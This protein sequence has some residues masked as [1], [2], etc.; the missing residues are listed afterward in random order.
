MMQNA[1]GSHGMVRFGRTRRAAPSH[2]NDARNPDCADARWRGL[3][4]PK[5]PTRSYSNFGKHDKGREASTPQILNSA[6]AGSNVD[7]WSK[8]KTIRRWGRERKDPYTCR[9]LSMAGSLLTAI[10]MHGH[11]QF[12]QSVLLLVLSTKYS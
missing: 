6:M 4:D 11:C 8:T 10:R 2:S 7:E 9:S 1:K 12:R 3:F 5:R